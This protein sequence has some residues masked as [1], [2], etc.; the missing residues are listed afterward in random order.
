MFQAAGQ[1][2]EQA[3]RFGARAYGNSDIVG[4]PRLVEM[5]N[6]HPLPAKRRSQLGAAMGRVACENKVCFRWQHFETKPRQP[7]GHPISFFHH[8]RAV[9]LEMLLILQG[10][11]GTGLGG[12]AERIGIKAVLDSDQR[13][14]Q[15]NSPI[16]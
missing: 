7:P 12:A 5:A 16:A 10:R 1:G 6:Q 3:V 4:Y 15:P 9:A 11:D 8:H 13:L 14:N 2:C